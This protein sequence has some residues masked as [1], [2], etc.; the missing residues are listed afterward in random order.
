MKWRASLISVFMV[1]LSVLSFGAVKEFGNDIKYPAQAAFSLINSGGAVDKTAVFSSI[2]SLAQEYD[3]QVY[4]P[5]I[6]K[7]GEQATFV[8]HP[9][10]NDESYVTN[11]DS[12]LN[13]DVS[14][15]YYTSKSVP[16]AFREQLESY[17]LIV[18]AADI[19]WYMIPVYFLFTNLRS[20]AVW[21]LFFVFALGLLAVKLM[22]A[23][24]AM[25]Y[26]SLGQ[27]G[28]IQQKH[29]LQ[30][31][32]S[33]LFNY[34]I[35]L[36]GFILYQGT[37][38]NV[39]VKTYLLLMGVN[40]LILLGITC[41]VNGIYGLNIRWIK[42]ISILKNKPATRFVLWVWLVGICLSTS[43]FGLTLHKSLD[44]IARSHSQIEV[45]DK[46][47]VAKGFATI[48]WFN[49]MSENMD[50]NHQ[51]DGQFMK[52]QT[53]KY[54]MFIQSFEQE[55]MLYSAPSAFG[56]ATSSHLP[57][58]LQEELNANGI[59]PQLASA[60]RYVNKGFIEKNKQLYP[61]NQYGNPSTESVGIIYIPENQLENTEN[62]RAIVAHEWFQYSSLSASDLTV[63]PVPSQQK[64]FLFN[65]TGDEHELFT[66]QEKTDAILVALN[67]DYFTEDA[68]ETAF[69]NIAHVGIFKQSII[70]EKITSA[71]LTNFSSLTNVAEKLLL[72]RNRLNS[73]LTGSVI[74]LTILFICQL[75]IMYEYVTTI[76]KKCAKKLAIYSL[77]GSQNYQVIL[78][79]LLPILVING[80]SAVVV[81]LLT[82]H[83]SVVFLV[84]GMFMLELLIMSLLSYHLVMKKRVQIIKG[85]FKAV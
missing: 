23:K 83:P 24:Q 9:T 73:Q 78:R 10:K 50:A 37:F 33:L 72:E 3:I 80:I 51:I 59:K 75:F 7:N 28:A 44:M 58:P 22:Y 71:G 34:M 12:L 79:N 17:G 76:M 20:L 19:S 5:F 30:D 39:F 21:T 27:F 53:E 63:Q 4:R 11:I 69:L 65:H 82:L 35:L 18:Q 13:S 1:L 41:F 52:E 84:W 14:G 8:F 46:W 56:E 2:E 68:L 16:A 25:I 70:Q 57:V 47:E 66:T 43:I 61:T 74:A 15:M 38:S 40:S 64:T 60:I 67:V 29:I 45:L 49:S 85:D 81:W 26:R 77:L 55:D 42:P 31:I 54:R 6:D 36:L 62:V 32:G 48:T